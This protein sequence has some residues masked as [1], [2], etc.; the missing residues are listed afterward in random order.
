MSA[1][2]LG[3]RFPF[4]DTFV[5]CYL[6]I[7]L[8][9][10]LPFTGFVAPYSPWP[11]SYNYLQAKSIGRDKASDPDSIFCMDL[12]LPIHDYVFLPYVPR[13]RLDLLNK[14]MKCNLLEL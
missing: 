1:T 8:M 6:S 10:Y 13:D 7:D 11:Q 12:L 9:V 3:P 5:L 2:S 14:A 4:N